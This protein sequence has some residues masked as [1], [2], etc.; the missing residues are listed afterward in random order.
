TASAGA[1]NR[2]PPR[3]RR[4]RSRASVAGRRAPRRR[5]A[6]RGALALA[7]GALL[8][9]MLADRPGCRRWAAGSAADDAA[10]R[11]PGSAPAAVG[12]VVLVVLRGVLRGRCGA[13][14]R[15]RG[16]HRKYGGGRR[17]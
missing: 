12:L 6:P 3:A 14:G 4:S 2:R 8:P 10:V 17:G 11:G 16:G 15:R 13:R 1:R 7:W 5:P 9:A